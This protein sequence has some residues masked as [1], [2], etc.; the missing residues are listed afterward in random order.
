MSYTDKAFT[1]LDDWR[2]L[3]SYQLERRA[4]IFFAVYLPE[5]AQKFLDLEPRAIIPEFPVRIGGPKRRKSSN[6]SFKIDY[7]IRAKHGARVVFLELKTDMKSKRGKQDKYLREASE[8]GMLK[9]IDGLGLIYS[10]TRQRAKYDSLFAQLAKAGFVESPISHPLHIVKRNYKTEIAYIQPWH[11]AAEG[12]K[13]ITFREISQLLR[14]KRDE[15]SRRFAE[16]LDK[17]AEIEAGRQ[18]G[19]A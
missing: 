14:R 8:A 9:L 1:L 17:W 6:R 12:A 5:I 15:L 10:A 3:P 16:S 19:A 13:V 11:D 2:H 7:L 18:I 4:D